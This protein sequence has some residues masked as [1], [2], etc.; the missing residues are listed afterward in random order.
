M[1]CIGDLYVEIQMCV[2]LKCELEMNCDI[3]NSEKFETYSE[4]ENVI[5]TLFGFFRCCEHLDIRNSSF[6]LLI[7]KLCIFEIWILWKFMRES[8][9]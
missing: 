9:M 3:W 5:W 1:V 2:W 4:K 7:G 6:Q 8:D